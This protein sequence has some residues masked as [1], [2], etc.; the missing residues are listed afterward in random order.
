MKIIR[1]KFIPFR[2][3]DAMNLFGVLFVNEYE[4]KGG[5]SKKTINH[6]RIHTA[7][8]IEMLFIGFYIWY[9][10][11]YLFT[12]PFFGQYES[13]MRGALEEEAYQH[14]KDLDYLSKRKP[15]AWV[16]YL[17]TPKWIKKLLN[18]FK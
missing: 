17:N 7:Q 5:L 9:G 8:M 10:V 11:E 4:V 14:E 13:Y 6:E 3:Y 12:R 16:Q 2:P 1:N 18:L 15:Y